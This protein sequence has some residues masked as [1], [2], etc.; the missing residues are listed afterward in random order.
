LI[1]IRVR[2]ALHGSERVIVKFQEAAFDSGGS[3][4]SDFVF[5]VSR[6]ALDRRDENW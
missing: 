4:Q 3:G 5:S 2:P 1:P 6:R